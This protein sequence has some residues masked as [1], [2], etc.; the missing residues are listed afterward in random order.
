MSNTSKNALLLVAH[1]SRRQASNDEV[2]ALANLL[3]SQGVYAFCESAF[4]ELAKPSIGEGFEALVAQGA[5]HIDVVPYFLAA[6]RHVVE[7]IPEEVAECQK[8]HPH[9]QVRLA[10]HLA[11]LQTKMAELVFNLAEQAKPIGPE[12]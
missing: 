3:S 8:A 9:I 11:E 2:S 6:G 5:T 1:G 4:L 7:D 12:A 10:P